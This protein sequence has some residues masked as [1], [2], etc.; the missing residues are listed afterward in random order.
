MY[1]A[2]Y[3]C[4]FGDFLIK[5]SMSGIISL[6]KDKIINEAEQ[7]INDHIQ[8]LIKELDLYFEGKLTEFS[9]P[10]D[11][12]A[13]TDFQQDVWQS[14]MNIPY[15]KTCSYKDLA[16]QLGDQ[17]KIRAVGKANGSNPIPIVIPCHRVIGS[18]GSMIG[19]ALG[20]EMKIALL[21]LEGMAVQG[22]LF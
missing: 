16:I 22:S 12:S 6:T 11:I 2:N 9:V 20:I 1:L 21:K 15:G 7:N 4:E 19:Y 18:D 3:H 17:K 13:Y 10:C 5:S 14:L 8:L